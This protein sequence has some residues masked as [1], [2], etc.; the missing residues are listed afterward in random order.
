MEEFLFED[1]LLESMEIISFEER[2][3]DEVLRENAHALLDAEMDLDEIL[4]ESGS[5]IVTE[6]VGSSIKEWAKKL[7]EKIVNMWKKFIDWIKNLM[8]KS[9]SVESSKSQSDNKNDSTAKKNNDTGSGQQKDNHKND[10][11]NNKSG[12]TKQKETKSYTV[13]SEPINKSKTQPE[14]KTKQFKSKSDIVKEFKFEAPYFYYGPLNLLFKEVL[15]YVSVSESK[16]SRFKK[17]SDESIAKVIQEESESIVNKI[18]DDIEKARKKGEEPKDIVEEVIN[19]DGTIISLNDNVPIQQFLRIQRE[20]EQAKDIMV[21]LAETADAEKSHESIKRYISAHATCVTKTMQFA[22][23][24]IR[25][26]KDS[27]MKCISSFKTEL[28]KYKH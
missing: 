12:D 21:K 1:S 8:K 23:N 11:D 20:L 24:A 27:R 14:Q 26:N 15:N 25:V 19:S 18:N 17:N 13:K 5:E 4:Y 6:G 22:V 9:D 2:D 3:I 10:K 7:W 28:N 16:Y